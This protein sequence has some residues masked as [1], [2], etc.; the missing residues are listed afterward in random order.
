MKGGEPVIMENFNDDSLYESEN[1][2]EEFA[3]L[4]L[5][6]AYRA[7]QEA[8]TKALSQPSPVPAVTPETENALESFSDDTIEDA[9]QSIMDYGA[10]LVVSIDHETAQD[11]I[12]VL[13]KRYGVAPE[14]TF[15]HVDVLVDRK[16]PVAQIDITPASNKELHDLWG[17]L[18]VYDELYNRD[19]TADNF[20]TRFLLAFLPEAYA[21]TLWLGAANPLSI[22]LCAPDIDGKASFVRIICAVDNVGMFEESAFNT[23]VPD[24][25]EAQ[26]EAKEKAKQEYRDR[27]GQ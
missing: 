9:L 3:F 15:S 25:Y 1:L 7:Q 10:S 4:R 14:L 11:D 20:G 23:V 6:A 22:A 21:G 26:E 2:E 13:A 27:Y 8:E 18:Q 12:P 16:Y 19:R 24:M 5:N 17:M